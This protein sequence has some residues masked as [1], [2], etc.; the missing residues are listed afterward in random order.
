MQSRGSIMK[1][2]SQFNLPSKE[3][4][5]IR[6]N[7]TLKMEV[8]ALKVCLRGIVYMA[9]TGLHTKNEIAFARRIAEAKELCK[10]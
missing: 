9:E 1:E 10:L 2:F 6:E 8:E 5:E 7:D 4:K 3:I